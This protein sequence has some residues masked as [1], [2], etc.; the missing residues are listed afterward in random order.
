MSQ[1]N[2]EYKNSNRVKN[3][4]NVFFRF[5]VTLMYFTLFVILMCI[6]EHLQGNSLQI[7]KAMS[8]ACVVGA[9]FNMLCVAVK[10]TFCPKKYYSIVTFIGIFMPF[11]LFLSLYLVSLNDL[12][13]FRSYAF[14]IIF[15][16][17]YM[18]LPCIK[19][20]ENSFN[21]IAMI[22]L[23]SVFSSFIFSVVL[24]AGLYVI[25]Y[26]ADYLFE[27]APLE[28]IF[29]YAFYICVYI[30][31]LSFLS[32]LP[33]Y[34]NQNKIEAPEM[35]LNVK[36]IVSYIV[37]PVVFAFSAVFASYFIKIFVTGIWPSNQ[38]VQ[39]TVIFSIAG[40]SIYMLVGNI[41]LKLCAVYKKIFPVICIVF[42]IMA[43]IAVFKRISVY[44][45]T[46]NRYFAILIVAF[47]IVCCLIY[48]IKQKIYLVATV[49][50]FCFFT[51]ISC[52]PFINFFEVSCYSQMLRAQDILERN[53]MLE[54][55]VL[56][57][58]VELA[59]Y[60]M[61]ELY[62]SVEYFTLK[63]KAQMAYWLPHGFVM[64]DFERCFGYFDNTQTENNGFYYRN[65]ILQPSD[66]SVSG[67]DI[68]INAQTEYLETGVVSSAEFKGNRGEYYY[69]LVS[70]NSNGSMKLV[71]KRNG[72]I[73][74]ESD[75]GDMV[76]YFKNEAMNDTD[77]SHINAME[78]PMPLEKMSTVL[79]GENSR[80]YVV[81]TTVT[82]NR[83]MDLDYQY[84]DSLNVVANVYLDEYYNN[85]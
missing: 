52:L 72:K 79:Y 33:K 11:L 45:I 17:G 55:G 20:A 29:T 67:Y 54:S 57:S 30:F 28:K 81:F 21:K 8:M 76:S 43:A 37:V 19:N 39:A 56:K 24:C 35:S 16:L 26:A 48:L 73:I 10:E 71:L 15:F 75:F 53:Y 38:I 18:L 4:I 3:L 78:V 80:L 5:P 25:I 69:E 34:T 74:I 27:F 49:F 47:S 7:I 66:Y 82:D 68:C 77:S 85:R 23:R 64:S 61:Q 83:S 41:S 65:Y 59:S 22:V 14:G 70:S 44:G 46:Y 62:N 9:F 40:I 2:S 1:S 12:W 42:N 13:L 6:R 31:A 36:M 63:D 84:L 58:D 60:D 50:V 32:K 51:G